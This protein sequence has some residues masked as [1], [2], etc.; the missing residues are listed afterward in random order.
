MTDARHSDWIDG[1][2]HMTDASHMTDV[3]VWSHD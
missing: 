2:G 1:V 3:R